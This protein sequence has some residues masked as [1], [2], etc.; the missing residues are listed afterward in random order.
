MNLVDVVNKLDINAD[1]LGLREYKENTTYHVIRD[2]NPLSNEGSI[3]HGIMV[4]VLKNGQFG[5]SGTSDLSFD[6]VLMAAN[7]ALDSASR[8]SEHS[9][10]SFDKDVRPNSTGSYETPLEL[11]FDSLSAG[12]INDI[13]MKAN[14]WLKIDDRIIS[15]SAMAM[16]VE[17]TINYACSNGSNIHQRM[18]IVG[19]DYSAT[20]K[21]GDIIQTRTDGRS[22]NQ[23]G[24]ERFN[25]D[26]V[27]EKCE[28]VS[29][30]VIEL[31]EADQCPTGT[32]SLVLAPDQMMLQIH[33]S[34]GHALEIDRILGDER[35]YA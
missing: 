6:G 18:N 15:V 17:T 29:D 13:L 9:V 5:Y 11:P 21:N 30:Q 10:F 25:Q 19:S 31:I 27:R 22:G 34:I 14:E 24:L 3:D 32:M 26:L 2:N 33:E 7:K 16:L 20:A 35:N 12:E 4:E 8:A 28:K 1:W 23:M